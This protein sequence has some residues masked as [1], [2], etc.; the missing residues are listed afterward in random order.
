MGDQLP[1]S[2]RRRRLLAAVSGTIAVGLAGCSGD[3]DS[4][5]GNGDDTVPSEYETATSIGG[6]E[7]DP[8]ALSSKDAVSYQEEPNDGEQCS[9]CQYYIEDKNDDGQ[10]ACAIVEGNIA[11]EAWCASYVVQ[12]G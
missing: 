1:D 5:N 10:G 2:E 11:P 9:G 4:G 12:D 7:R 8:E 3:G 6:V